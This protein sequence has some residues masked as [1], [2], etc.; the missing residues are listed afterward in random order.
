MV[1]DIVFNCEY[2]FIEVPNSDPGTVAAIEPQTEY[3][4]I[5][6]ALPERIAIS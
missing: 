1:D 3:F 4:P 6:L 5:R 2:F